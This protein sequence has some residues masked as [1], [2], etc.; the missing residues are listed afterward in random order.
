MESF[1]ISFLIFQL[2]ACKESICVLHIFILC[3]SKFIRES[4]SNLV[5]YETYIKKII[6][7]QP[8]KKS[9]E[10]HSPTTSKEKQPQQQPST[11]KTLTKRPQV[12]T[13]HTKQR[14]IIIQ[15]KPKAKPKPRV[16]SNNRNQ[17]QTPTTAHE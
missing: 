10:H 14:A 2:G 7:S 17:S 1:S 6:S 4:V 15:H 11:T 3:R 9:E 8:T 5:L 16:G 13:T 12:P